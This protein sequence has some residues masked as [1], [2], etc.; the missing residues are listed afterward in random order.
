MDTYQCDNCLTTFS[1]EELADG[2]GH[3]TDYTATCGPC[4]RE[5][6]RRLSASFAAGA[7]WWSDRQQE[8]DLIG[9]TPREG[10][11]LALMQ[12]RS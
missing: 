2:E 3:V 9:F 4:D 10:N 11:R 7:R 12:A 6:D 8:A 1:D 5:N